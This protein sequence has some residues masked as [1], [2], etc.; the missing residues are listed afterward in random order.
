MAKK[1]AARQQPATKTSGTYRMGAGT[2]MGGAVY[3]P[4]GG[5]VHEVHYAQR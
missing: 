4:R 5:Q 1:Q 2:E 3:G